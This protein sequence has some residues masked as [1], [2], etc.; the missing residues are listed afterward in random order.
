MYVFLRVTIFPYFKWETGS[1]LSPLNV[2]FHI[3]LRFMYGCVQ[4]TMSK[5]SNINPTN[6]FKLGWRW[7]D[8]IVSS[9]PLG[10]A[11]NTNI[12]SIPGRMRLAQRSH[13]DSIGGPIKAT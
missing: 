5:Q 9:A 6:N 2:I 11:T 4:Y 8:S 1:A 3:I 7:L 13:Y 12:G 10:R